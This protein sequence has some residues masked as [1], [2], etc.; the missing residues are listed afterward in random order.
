MAAGIVGP[1]R[2]RLRRPETAEDVSAA[3]DAE[4]TVRAVP[5]Q[6]LVPELLVQRHIAGE[7]V[8]RQ[9]SFEE[10]VVPAVAVTPR[11]AEHARDGVRL[12]HGAHGVRRHPEPVGRRPAL[13]L[14]IERRQRAVRADSLE[15]P[16][17]HLGVLV[18]DPRR[19]PAQDPAEPR[20]LARRDEGESLVVRLEDLAALVEEV[21]PAGVVVGD[22]RVQHEVVASTGDREG[23]ELDRAESAE[24]LEHGLGTSLE[25]SRRREEVPGDEK[26]ARS[27]SG[28]SHREE[29]ST[30]TSIRSRALAGIHDAAAPRWRA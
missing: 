11:E 22:A 1:P 19:A 13:T 21:A 25:G 9:Q 8:G 23:I 7:H 15:H 6:E 18:Q 20:E 16:V 28:D 14:E 29:T 24:D 30:R 10:V 3:A 12:E 4:Q 17:G 26:T 2:I 27:L 5:G